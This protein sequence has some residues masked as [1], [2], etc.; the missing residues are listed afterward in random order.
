MHTKHS[1]VRGSLRNFSTTVVKA[2][3]SKESVLQLTNAAKYCEGEVKKFDINSYI[4]GHY[5]PAK[6]RAY[7]FGNHA[8]FIE[9][10]KSREISKEPSICQTRLRWWEATL[11]EI[12]KSESKEDF[13]PR[14]PLAVVLHHAKLYSQMNF[15]LH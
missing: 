15:N 2:E 3:P 9:V 1:F 10:L 13:T 6:T 4:V 8:L 11:G 12:V 14:E 5:M 7:Y